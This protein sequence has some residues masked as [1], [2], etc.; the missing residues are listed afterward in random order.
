MIRNSTRKLKSLL[1]NSSIREA[2]FGKMGMIGCYIALDNEQISQLAE[3]GELSE[4]LEHDGADQLDIDKAWQGIHYLLCGSIDDGPP[5]LGYVVPMM[6]KQGIDYGDFGAFFL[7]HEQVAAASQALADLTEQKARQLY[8][9]NEMV[10]AGVYPIVSNE[11]EGEFFDYIW[12][13]LTEI[14]Q[15]YQKVAAAGKGLIFY[16]M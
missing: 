15:F 4:E 14:R 3:G 7:H 1:P 6:D 12:T 13:Y 9:F 5:P 10:E 11:D 16:I 8:A 2:G